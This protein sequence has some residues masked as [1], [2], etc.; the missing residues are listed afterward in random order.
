MAYTYDYPIAPTPVTP[1]PDPMQFSQQTKQIL[2]NA[3]PGLDNLS[4]GASGVVNNLLGGMPSPSTAR[5]ANAYFGTASGMPGSDFVRNR[6]FDLYGQQADQYRQRGFDDFLNLLKGASGTI[7]PT[8]GE[9]A[10]NQQFGQTFAQHQ[11]ENN[12]ANQKYNAEFARTSPRGVQPDS[13][14]TYDVNGLKPLFGY[15]SGRV[16]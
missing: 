2:G 7:A 1:P 3:I 4:S 15:G 5:K 13:F 14:T 6:G 8:P 11:L 10:Q 16:I 12:Q 9:Q